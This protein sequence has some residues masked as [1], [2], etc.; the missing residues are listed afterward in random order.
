MK[1]D[2]RHEP[3]TPRFSFSKQL[4]VLPTLYART[5]TLLKF[6]INIIPQKS[7]LSIFFIYFIEK[8]IIM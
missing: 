6:N 3:Q 8:I 1:R 7:V 2:A 4:P 5:L